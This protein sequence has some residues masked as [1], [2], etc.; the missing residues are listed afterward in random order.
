M[1]GSQPPIKNARG[2]LAKYRDDAICMMH[3]GFV[4]TCSSQRRVHTTALIFLKRK[5]SGQDVY[6]YA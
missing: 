6:G 1:L 2:L 4:Q 3:A 5:L